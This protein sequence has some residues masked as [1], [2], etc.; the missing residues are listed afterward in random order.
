M[1][2]FQLM[3]DRCRVVRCLFGCL[4]QCICMDGVVREVNAR[5]LGI[6]QEL[7]RAE[8]RRFEINQRL[9]P[10]NTALVADSEEKFCRLLG[11]FC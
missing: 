9:L 7:L 5:V 6:M 10:D 3:L 1:S 2:D 4:M 11:G 8:G